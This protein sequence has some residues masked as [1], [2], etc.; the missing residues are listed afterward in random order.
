MTLLR[1]VSER[2]FVL[3]C[4]LFGD[5]SS[6]SLSR[7]LFSVHLFISVSLLCASLYLGVSSLC[8]SLSRCLFSV[9]LFISVS[10][11]CA[12]LYLGVSSLCFSLSRCLFSVHLFISVSLLCASLY[13]GV[14]SISVCLF[15]FICL[16]FLCP[17]VLSPAPQIQCLR[18][19]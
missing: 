6:A 7:C 18:L 3:F 11:L 12:S 19:E 2:S 16:F 5:L 8:F 4:Y 10:L 1:C 17:C 15:L 14:S 13:L 9:H